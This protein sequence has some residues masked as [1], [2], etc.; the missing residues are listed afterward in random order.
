MPV[1]QD[2]SPL[3]HVLPIALP[4]VGKQ[5]YKFAFSQRALLLW[6]L[7]TF[8]HDYRCVPSLHPGTYM[9]SLRWCAYPHTHSSAFTL[10]DNAQALSPSL[11]FSP[12]FILQFPIL[13]KPVPMPFRPSDRNKCI[14]VDRDNSS[15]MVTRCSDVIF[16]F[17]LGPSPQCLNPKEY[18]GWWDEHLRC[19]PCHKYD[20]KVAPSSAPLTANRTEPHVSHIYPELRRQ[21]VL[22]ISTC[23]RLWMTFPNSPPLA[24][25][26]TRSPATNPGLLSREAGG[27]L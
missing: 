20:H 7:P 12:E 4:R 10:Q 3:S 14:P 6:I 2:T 18:L 16:A 27:S 23:L 13:S 26:S 21:P 22:V 19:R 25:P 8:G 9:S 15:I 11:H 17:Q 5:S 1:P 24:S